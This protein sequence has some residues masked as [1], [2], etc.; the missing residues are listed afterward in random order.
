MTRL[1]KLTAL[2]LLALATTAAAQPRIV[3][4][5]QTA[6]LTESQYEPIWKQTIH[7]DG[8]ATWIDGCAGRHDVPH[9]HTEP[10]GSHSDGG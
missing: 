6:N 7:A 5:W 9:D 3:V 4:Q 8:A 10:T 1:S 2:A